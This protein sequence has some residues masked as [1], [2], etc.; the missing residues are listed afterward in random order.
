M[1]IITIYGHFDVCMLVF[2]SINYNF[3]LYSSATLGVIVTLMIEVVLT[4]YNIIFEFLR[5]NYPSTKTNSIV[6]YSV[7]VAV[8]IITNYYIMLLC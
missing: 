3:Y 2:E 8:F 6:I 4:L 1:G 5:I 7:L